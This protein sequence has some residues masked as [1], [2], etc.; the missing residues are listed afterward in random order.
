MAAREHGGESAL[1]YHV[2]SG[3]VVVWGT[4]SFAVPCLYH[5]CVWGSVRA[6]R[7]SFGVRRRTDVNI[8]FGPASCSAVRIKIHSQVRAGSSGGEMCPFR[9][10]A[11]RVTLPR[12]PP[13]F[14]FPPRY[15]WHGGLRKF[16]P[17]SKNLEDGP[18]ELL[19]YACS[20]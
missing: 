2:F 11:E 7:V 1:Q 20:R 3:V 14:G 6:R 19:G 16:P 9:E 10:V 8:S 5:F 13:F 17:T 18:R 15:G 12:A 4:M